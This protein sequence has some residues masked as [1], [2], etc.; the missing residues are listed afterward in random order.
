MQM[1]SLKEIIAEAG[2]FKMG[3]LCHEAYLLGLSVA[4]AILHSNTVVKY[5][6]QYGGAKMVHPGTALRG[7]DFPATYAIRI[8]VD[9]AE[10]EQITKK[11]RDGELTGDLIMILVRPE[12]LVLEGH[13]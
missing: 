4:S 8:M 5:R 13:E 9:K 7:T 3:Q 1:R 12:A 2:D 6:C 11:G 10:Y